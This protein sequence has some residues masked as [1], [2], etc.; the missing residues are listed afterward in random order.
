MLPLRVGF[1]HQHV[2]ITVGY[3]CA[4]FREDQGSCN[5]RRK[6]LFNQIDNKSNIQCT[7]PNVVPSIRPKKK[8]SK[9]HSLILDGRGVLYIHMYVGE[10]GGEEGLQSIK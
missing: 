7:L 8:I 2:P 9:N 3:R 1:P 5:T 10:K 6:I 4:N